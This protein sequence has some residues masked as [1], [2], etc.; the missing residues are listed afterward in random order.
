LG[1]IRRPHPDR[2]H[3]RFGSQMFTVRK[4][5]VFLS[6]SAAPFLNMLMVR[7]CLFLA[8]F[9]C[10][11]KILLRLKSLQFSFVA[12]SPG[13]SVCEKIF[14]GKGAIRECNLALMALYCQQ[15]P[16]FVF[17]EMKLCGLDPN[18][19]NHVSVSDLYISTIGLPILLQ[20]NRRTDHGNWELGLA[21]KFLGIFVSNF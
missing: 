3:T 15:D 1:G 2:T 4:V 14:L 9:Y 11:K 19:Y 17:P 18:F 12:F 13:S 20:Q 8:F 21:F 10:L 5:F 16:I 7:S 6:D